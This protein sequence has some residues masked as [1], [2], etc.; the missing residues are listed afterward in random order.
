MVSINDHPDIRRAF[1]GVPMLGLSIR[2]SVNNTAGRGPSASRELVI[3][4]WEPG[5][6]WDG[7]F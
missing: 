7:L 1:D 6:Q 2:Y 3:T 5:T 4:D